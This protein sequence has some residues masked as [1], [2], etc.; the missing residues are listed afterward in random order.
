M[1]KL[2]II[3]AMVLLLVACGQTERTVELPNTTAIIVASATSAASPTPEPSA[4]PTSPTSQLRSTEQPTFPVPA[5]PTV[6]A[7]A[8]DALVDEALTTLAE[9]LEVD[10]ATLTL[11]SSQAVEWSDGALG[12][13]DPSFGYTQAI[14]PGYLL[15]VSDGT[16]E[17]A[18][19]TSDQANPIILCQDGL[20]VMLQDLGP[21]E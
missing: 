2:T 14:V 4:I 21:A 15:V 17:Y 1:R 6:P 7:A 19:H 12:C 13:P 5:T 11:I 20:P 3:C 10:E 16:Q 9:H 8:P 18:L